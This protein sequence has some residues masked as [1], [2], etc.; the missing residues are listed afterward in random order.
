MK[1]LTV[2]DAEEGFTLSAPDD[3]ECA[4]WLTYWNQDEAHHEVFEKEFNKVL[5]HYLNRTLEE[6]G[7]AEAI[8]HEQSGRREQTEND[9]SGS[10]S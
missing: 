4:A 7:E 6:H 2:E 9:L 10:Q 5:T 8:S 3:T 1:D